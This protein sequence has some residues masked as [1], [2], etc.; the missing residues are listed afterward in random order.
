M[1]ISSNSAKQSLILVVLPLQNRFWKLLGLFWKIGLFSAKIFLTAERKF[2]FRESKLLSTFAGSQ[3]LCYRLCYFLILI[4]FCFCICCKHL[5][6][7]VAYLK[8][9]LLV[10][11]T[12]NFFYFQLSPATKNILIWLYLAHLGTQL[13]WKE[14]S[15]PFFWLFYF[16][17][18]F[19]DVNLKWNC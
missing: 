12:F 10:A 16:I 14:E 8:Y 19:D 18:F 6:D 13:L 5:K 4:C 9:L 15:K 7:Y 2:H 17:L 11:P 3:K 1:Q